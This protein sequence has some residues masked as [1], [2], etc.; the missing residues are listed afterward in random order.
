VFPVI[1]VMCAALADA[2]G[3]HHLAFY[4]LL[5][6]VPLAAVAA[7]DAFGRFLDARDDTLLALQALLWGL[8]LSLVVLS[9]GVRSNAVGAVPR[10]AVTATLA[11]VAVFA[12]KGCFAAAPFLR[13]LVSLRPAKP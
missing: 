1:L 12:I 5:A 6:A 11:C 4:A 3:A 13:R 7:L 10:L 2:R 8:A 9:C